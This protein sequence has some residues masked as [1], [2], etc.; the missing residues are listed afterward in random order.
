MYLYR[1]LQKGMEFLLK[2]CWIMSNK[3]NYVDNGQVFTT[4]IS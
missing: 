1:T 2:T 4:A 3:N